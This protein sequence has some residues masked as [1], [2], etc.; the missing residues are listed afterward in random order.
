VKIDRKARLKIPRQ[1]LPKQDPEVRITNW[2]E[3]SLPIDLEVAKVEALRCIQCPAAPCQKA[4]PVG[5]DIPGALWQ[6]EQG[7]I[8]GAAEVFY[9]TSNLPE[10]CGRLCP[11]ERLCEGHCVVGKNAPPVAIGRLEAFVADHYRHHGGYEELE[12]A[13]PTGHRVAVVGAGPA[14]LGAAE[15]LARLGHGVTVFDAWPAPGGVL[16]YGIPNFKMEKEV[17]D[18]K[19]QQLRDLGVEFVQNT[20]VERDVTV[21]Q[22]LNKGFGAVL[23]AHGASLGTPLD[24]PGADLPGVLL[25]TEFLVRG[26]VDTSQRPAW[27]QTPLDAG[28]KVLVI[29]GGDTS[30]DCVR[31]AVRLGARE[32][33]CAYR[34]TEAEQLV[35]E[36]ERV[37]AR[38][39][40][41]RFEYLA[42][43]LQMEAGNDGRVARVRFARMMLGEADDSGRRRPVPTGEQFDVEATTVV[44]AIGYRA[45]EDLAAR[46]RIE[47][48]ADLVAVNRETF[49]T[50]RPGVFAAG[51]C[52]N[53]ADLVV[54]ALADARRAAA[55]IH[56]FLL[57][58]VGASA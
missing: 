28:D 2:R 49:E 16:L 58:T 4:C 23:L 17:L 44:V 50:N 53:G 55:A 45:D 5:N 52:V 10:M 38:E 32:V 35:R 8:Q 19:V 39:E 57:N 43:P 24:I 25:A 29:G 21:D 15:Q 18:T 33:M 47:H 48:A 13:A 1:H 40:G 9:Q 22:L 56:S 27:M 41:V 12:R 14:G 31:T 36:E 3:A 34:R 46:A 26:N 42:S 11:Q 20:Y 54:T 37:H 7:D 30:M 51:D 6:L